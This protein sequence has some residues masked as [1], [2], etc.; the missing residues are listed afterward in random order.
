MRLSLQVSRDMKSIA[1]GPL[2]PSLMENMNKEFQGDANGDASQHRS[3]HAIRCKNSS[4]VHSRFGNPL[5]CLATMQPSVHITNG[6]NAGHSAQN[7]GTVMVT[8]KWHYHFRNSELFITNSFPQWIFL[9][10]LN[11][12]LGPHSGL[13]SLKLF[14]RQKKA[15][16]IDVPQDSLRKTD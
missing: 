3:G 14:L 1:A 10:P 16:R 5:R 8:T 4:D 7:L 2:S 11:P 15:G 12:N 13:K 6:C 9:Q